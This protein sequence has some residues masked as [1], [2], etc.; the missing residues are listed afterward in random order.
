MGSRATGGVLEFLMAISMAPPASRISPT[1]AA[2]L[3]MLLGA[4]LETEAERISRSGLARS[5]FQDAKRRVYA[6][7]LVED[8][9]VPNPPVFGCR[10]AT[11]L[12]A[13]PYA[14]EAA[15]LVER[16][17]KAPDNVLL[18]K[19]LHM[20]F[21]VFLHA[22]PSPSVGN[23]RGAKGTASS[24]ITSITAD[25][26][27]AS[28]PVYFDFEGAWANLS[29]GSRLWQY[30]R[31]LVLDPARS[32]EAASEG[33]R[34]IAQGLVERTGAGEP[35]PESDRAPHLMGPYALPKSSRRLVDHGWLQW[36]VFPRLAALGL[37]DGRAVES[38]VLVVGTMKEGRQVAPLFREL[39]IRRSFP[40]FLGS[41]GRRVLF[42]FLSSR[43]SPSGNPSGAAEVLT[44]YL[45]QVE[46]Q[47]EPTGDLQEVVSHRY[48]GVLGLPVP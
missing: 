37:S 31:P 27:T 14:E 2:V 5:T 12:I 9:Y 38:I 17:R 13:R 25:L 40:F 24:P 28:L 8:R 7:G 6:R 36:R 47:R 16:W 34:R 3:A 35:G 10:W 15:P 48:G 41:D 45:T 39:V 22:G 20:V 18:W 4:S 1:E 26:L 30:P 32:T 19:G 44:E 23:G 46:A 29:G 43:T 42:G 11:A 21:G 33:S